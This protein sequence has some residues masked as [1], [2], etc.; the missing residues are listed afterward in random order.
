M[1]GSTGRPGRGM[2]ARGRGALGAVRSPRPRPAPLPCS[3]RMYNSL[4]E[5]CFRDC[6]DSF[7]RK[8]LD[9]TEEKVGGTGRCSVRMCMRVLRSAARA[10]APGGGAATVPITSP[11]AAA[12]AASAPPLH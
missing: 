5:R 4:V 9:A 11:A 3:L 10:A 1:Q 6:V 12:P 2:R 7:R 8:D